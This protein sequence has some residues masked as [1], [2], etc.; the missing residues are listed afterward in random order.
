MAVTLSDDEV[1]DHESKSDQERNF[2]AFTAIAEV[3]EPKIVME[4]PFD[5]ELFENAELARNLQ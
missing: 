2:M 4:N 3:S 1:S 5:K